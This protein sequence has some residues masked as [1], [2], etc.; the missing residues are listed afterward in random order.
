MIG[1]IIDSIKGKVSVK[2]QIKGARKLKWK[3]MKVSNASAKAAINDIISQLPTFELV[4]ESLRIQIGIKNSYS[5]YDGLPLY[6]LHYN[7][8]I[9]IIVLKPSRS[10]QVHR[11]QN[12]YVHSHQPVH[13]TWITN[14]EGK[15]CIQQK[16][17]SKPT[18]IKLT[19]RI[20][21]KEQQIKISNGTNLKKAC[22]IIIKHKP[23]LHIHL[24][25]FKFTRQEMDLASSSQIDTDIFGKKW[26]LFYHIS[27]HLT[28]NNDI[29]IHCRLKKSVPVKTSYCHKCGALGSGACPPKCETL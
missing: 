10:R 6:G 23:E 16:K 28:L 14:M 11:V 3:K 24:T 22:R 2:V 7:Q 5:T 20:G 18:K 29:K 1:S 4:K 13:N 25:E 9:T 21:N 19:I 26:K 17:Q 8:H 15:S 12:Q 27:P